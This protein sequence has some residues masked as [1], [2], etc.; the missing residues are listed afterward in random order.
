[1]CLGEAEIDWTEIGLGWR[2]VDVVV[3]K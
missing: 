3:A 2:D 1:V